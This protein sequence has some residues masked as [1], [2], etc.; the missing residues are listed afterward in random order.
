MKQKNVIS[1]FKKQHFLVKLLNH[2]LVNLITT[3]Q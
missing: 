3:F 1:K 2:F